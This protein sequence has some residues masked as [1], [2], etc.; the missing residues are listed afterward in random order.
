MRLYGLKDTVKENGMETREVDT[1]AKKRK[2]K[3]D[4][5]PSPITTVGK[6]KK[7]VARAV[8]KKGKGVLRINGKPLDVWNQTSR[9]R[10]KEAL[11][12]AG[13]L[14]KKVDISVNVSG[15]GITGQTDAVRQAIACAL[16][17]FSGGK[18][19]DK[20]MDYDRTLMVAD[21]RRTEPHKPSRSKA[22]PRRH[23]QKSK[24]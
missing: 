1:M 11:I 9:M 5:K 20:Y 15:G 10:I 6:R 22:G 19:R 21:S 13:E 18:L 12:L 3:K 7:A 14:P 8:I 2:K 24:R 4:K 17:E 23:K 16:N